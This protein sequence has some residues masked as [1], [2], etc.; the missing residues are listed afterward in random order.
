MSIKNASYDFPPLPAVL[1]I[2]LLDFTGF[3]SSKEPPDFHKFYLAV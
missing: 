2:F 1:L 3:Q